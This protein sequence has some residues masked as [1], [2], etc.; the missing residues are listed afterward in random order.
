MG[1]WGQ[2]CG[3]AAGSGV[4][5][6]G[7][8][9]PRPSRA[10]ASCESA[11]CECSLLQLTERTVSTPR[12]GILKSGGFP[13]PAP[14]CA[15]LRWS[16]ILAPKRVAPDASGPQGLA[17]PRRRFPGP[18]SVW[19]QTDPRAHTTPCPSC[20]PLP[21]GTFW[22]NVAMSAA[23]VRGSEMRFAGCSWQGLRFSTITRVSISPVGRS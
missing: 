5:L 19:W 14:R 7:R 20:R 6:W 16:P 8:V 22:L 4:I 11:L 13:Y 3:R 1:T 12:V 9:G 23:E 18:F 17:A 2:V 21:L 15:P 10:R